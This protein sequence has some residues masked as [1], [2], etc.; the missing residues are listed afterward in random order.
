M[1]EAFFASAGVQVVTEAG[2]QGGVKV[3]DV[4]VYRWDEDVNPQ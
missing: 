4:L 3:I 2:A 1:A